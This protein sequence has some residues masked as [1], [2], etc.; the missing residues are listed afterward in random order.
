MR[1]AVRSVLAIVVAFV[2]ASAI[3]AVVETVNGKVLYPGLHEAAS[4]VK[5]RE[6]I[7]Q[8][9][10]SAPI[11]ALLVVLLGWAV[12]TFVGGLIAARIASRAKAIHA[13]ALGV[14]VALA[15]IANN[16][17]LPPPIWFWVAGLA[18][19]LVAGWAAGRAAVPQP[20]P[21]PA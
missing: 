15:G 14:L 16:L 12:G 9:M 13:V 4:G 5:D 2:V 8:V 3:M 7:R 11:G 21:Q 17:A 10:A 6:G 20:Q 18:A 1:T 19:P